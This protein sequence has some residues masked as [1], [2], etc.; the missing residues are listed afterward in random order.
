[1]G[2]TSQT[3]SLQIAPGGVSKE[4]G[5]LSNCLFRGGCGDQLLGDDLWNSLRVQTGFFN[6][7]DFEF[8]ASPLNST[9]KIIVFSQQIFLI[10]TI[11]KNEK[12]PIDFYCY[13]NVYS[14]SSNAQ[15]KKFSST[16]DLVA[17]VFVADAQ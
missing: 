17:G 12:L 10:L 8:G 13:F 7:N 3:N 6:Q 14:Y 4:C 16:G 9:N 1:M 5:N 15:K 11:F 2:K